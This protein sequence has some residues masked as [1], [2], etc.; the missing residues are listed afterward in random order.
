MIYAFEGC[1]LD[2]DLRELVRDGQVVPVEPQVF[3]LIHLLVESAG[4][5]VTREEL[6]ERIWDGRIVS[7]A[8]IDSRIKSARKALGDDGAAQRL[9]R[10][11]RKQGLRFMGEV[12]A[13]SP[14]QPKPAEP[15]APPTLTAPPSIAVLP[16]TLV[17]IGGPHAGIAEAIP[18]DLI[19][20]L[21]RLRWLTVIARGSAFQFRGAEAAPERIRAALGVSY[22][23]SGVVEIGGARMVVS[24]ELADTADGRVVWGERYAGP[25]EAVHE[26]RAEIAH[27]VVG[28]LELQIPL[29]EARRALRGTED[30][31]AWSAYHLG[32]HHMYRFDRD[33]NAKAAGYFQTAIERDPSFSRALAG[34]SFTH[35]QDA[36]QSF[37]ADAPAA[38]REARRYAE[39]SLDQDPFD[40]FCN[41]VMGR[42]AWLTGELEA[43][44]PWISRANELNPN[45]AQGRY[46]EAWTGALLG[47]VSSPRSLVDQALSLSPL[48]PLLYGM[49]GVRAMTHITEGDL[50]AGAEWAERAARAPRA[51]ALIDVI[52]AVAHSLNGDEDRAANWRASALARHPGLDRTQFLTAFP[53]KDTPTRALIVSALDR[54]AL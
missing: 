37:A 42:A 19:V 28:A 23:L 6:I 34:L 21:S 13:S 51:H 22:V 29:N 20:E 8:A 25:L 31:D 16:F 46:A 3:D 45:Y 14:A 18:H 49:L 35:F 32:L 50:E 33:G 40:P 15:L 11:L 17:G 10:T 27:A 1:R 4:R 24:V 41:L 12:T 54:L 43:S 2:V 38:A 30:L 53:F 48:D 47:E 44:L 36:F 9:I 26:I 52:A 39:L 7:E 5:L